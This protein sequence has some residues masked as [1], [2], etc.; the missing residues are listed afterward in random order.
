MLQAVC[1]DLDGTLTRPRLDFAR[2]RAEIGPLFGEGTLL[3]QIDRMPPAERGRALSILHCHEADAADHAE[4][5]EGVAELLAFVRGRGLRAGI[6]TRNAEVTVSRTLARLGLDFEHVVTRDSGLPLKPD[7][8][9]VL[10]LCERW[11]LPPSRV[12]MVGDFRYDT[13]AGRA[14]GTLTCLVTNG[15]ETQDDG[16]DFVVT[17]PREVIRVIEE[18][19]AR[20]SRKQ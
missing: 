15:R 9:Q 13:E 1:F 3:E 18:A 11:R 10:H 6:V 19:E 7:P 17:T 16:A 2:L 8:A 12:L 5:N 4:L 14:A 20:L